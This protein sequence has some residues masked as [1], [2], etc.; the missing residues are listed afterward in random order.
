MLYRWIAV[1]APIGKRRPPCF[2]PLVRQNRFLAAVGK[3]MLLTE[4]G[5]VARQPGITC[6]GTGRL[7]LCRIHNHAGKPCMAD[8]ALFSSEI[9]E[10]LRLPP[11][12]ERNKKAELPQ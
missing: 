10:D 12:I 4:A 8:A 3:K 5:Q 11:G 7:R 9:V 1:G 2:Q 6:F